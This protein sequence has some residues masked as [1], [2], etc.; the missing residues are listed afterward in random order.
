MNCYSKMT[1]QPGNGEKAAP[2]AGLRSLKSTMFFRVVNF[3]L[4]ARP[5]IVV[6]ALGLTAMIGCSAYI[7]YM[8]SKYEDM[9]YYAAVESDGKETFKKKQSKWDT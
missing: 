3:E 6:M 9:G 1:S 2:G 8:R 5:N 4:Y 7:F